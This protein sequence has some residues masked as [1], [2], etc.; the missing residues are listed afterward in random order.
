M[1]V[2]DQAAQERRRRVAAVAQLAVHRLGHGVDDVEADGVGE[3]ERAHRVAAAELHRR[4]DRVGRRHARLERRDPVEQI[5]HEQAIDDVA[6]RVRH[7]HRRLAERARA[8]PA[9]P[10]RRRGRCAAW[11]RPRP[12]SSPAPARRSA[13]R[14]SAAARAARRPAPPAAATRCSTPAP[15]PS[16]RAARAR[17]RACACVEI[18]DD[19]LDH[20]VAA[21]RARRGPT[22]SVR[23][24][25]VSSSASGVSLPFLTA[26]P[27]D[28]AM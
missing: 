14:R 23:R 6:R 3:R 12:A 21:R 17:R 19:R 11:R 15:P 16:T 24:P 13:G 7:H 20:H 2:E 27:S 25:S 9:R 18:L 10:R 1:I 5:G 8:A 4:V 28:S 26:R 22:V